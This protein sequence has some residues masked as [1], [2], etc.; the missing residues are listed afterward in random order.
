MTINY[1]GRISLT[2]GAQ[3]ADGP[4]TP[5]FN[6][7]HQASG[8]TADWSESDSVNTK[9]GLFSVVLGQVTSLSALPGD[10]PYWLEVVWAGQTMSPRQPLTSAPYALWAGSVDLPLTGTTNSGGAAISV[11]NTGG[12]G[13]AGFGSTG[14]AG[15]GSLTGVQGQAASAG[16]TGV[17][18][19]YGGFGSS[20][21]LKVSG[22]AQFWGGPVSFTGGVD[23]SGAAVTGLSGGV[24]VPLTLSGA[25]AFP[26]TVL[27]A[28]NTGSGYAG[29]FNAGGSAPALLA[30]GSTV[31]LSATVSSLGP[32]AYVQ[33][34]GGGFKPALLAVTG[35]T[36]HGV[37]GDNTQFNSVGMLAGDPIG[38]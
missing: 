17:F 24:S 11:T 8:G 2:Y 28:T 4:Y 35:G 18:A 16:A 27:S 20:Y 6:L 38:G 5:V 23:F 3:V 21:A 25:V 12:P 7:Y 22:P 13:V 10:Q 26:G 34:N 9:N 37:E 31:A 36:G 30:Q 19:D 1:Q 29:V 15:K 14:V 33:A 32:A